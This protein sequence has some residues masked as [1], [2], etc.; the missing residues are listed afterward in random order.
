MSYFEGSTKYHAKNPLPLDLLVVDEASMIDLTLMAKLLWRF[1]T[2]DQID[3]VREIKTI[4][5]VGEAGAILAELEAVFRTR[6]IVRT[7]RII[8][9]KLLRERHCRM[10]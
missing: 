9:V 3:F 2:D 8:C 5:G 1:K 6:G 10:L 7:K 4:I